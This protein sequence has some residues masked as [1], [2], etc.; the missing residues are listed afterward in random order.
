[1]AA[2]SRA[3]TFTA[4]GSPRSVL[5]LAPRPT[6]ALPP[7][8]FLLA[9][10]K[11]LPH[12][13]DANEWLRVKVAYAVL[14]PG[15]QFYVSLITAFAR[16]NT[17]VPEMDLSGTV[18]DRG[19]RVLVNGASGGVGSLAVQMARAAVGPGGYVVG[20]CS[21]RNA[22]MVRELGADEVV[23]CTAAPAPVS[24]TLRASGRARG[25][26]VVKVNGE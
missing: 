23:D 11:P 14:N 20:V 12:A 22:D 6:P 25:K 2:T 4:R 3:W 9:K 19:G 15:G 18:T 10:A 24:E 7:P 21:G 5:S 17:A 26:V 16:T 1:M 13:Q 8:P